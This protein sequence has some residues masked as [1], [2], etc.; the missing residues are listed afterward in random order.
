MASSIHHRYP[1]TLIYV[2]VTMV[3]VLVTY[4][5]DSLAL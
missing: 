5:M 2:A 3:A 1:R 4:L